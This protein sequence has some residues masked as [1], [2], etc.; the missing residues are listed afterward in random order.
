MKV[1][2]RRVIEGSLQDKGFHKDQRDHRFWYFFYKGK[3]TIIR[4]KISTGKKYRVYGTD[5]L[6]MMQRQLHLDKL[7]E[8]KDLLVCPMDEDGYIKILLGKRVISS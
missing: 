1:I 3:K 8:V 2:D 6:Q 7:K 4:T 5:L